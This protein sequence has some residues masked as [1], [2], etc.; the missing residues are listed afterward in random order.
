M[1]IIPAKDKI[2][3]AVPA[4]PEIKWL[5]FMRLFKTTASDPMHISVYAEFCPFRRITTII[6][7]PVLK[8]GVPVIKEGTIVPLLDEKGDEQ[9]YPDRPEVDEKGNPVLDRDGN[10]VMLKGDVIMTEGE[11]VTEDKEI[12]VGAEFKP[13]EKDGD[14]TVIKVDN[15]MEQAATDAAGDAL[16]EKAIGGFLMAGGNL[17]ALALT[18]TTLAITQEGQRQGKFKA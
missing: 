15:L 12:V 8:D 16:I 18:A 2:S 4:K 10:P 11:P 7:V 1:D 9:R 14:I 13:D 17:T 6:Q 3:P 5:D